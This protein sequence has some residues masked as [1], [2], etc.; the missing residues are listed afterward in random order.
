MPDPL[1]SLTEPEAKSLPSALTNTHSRHPSKA[2]HHTAR[3]QRH[4]DQTG[5][6]RHVGVPTEDPERSTFNHRL[7]AWYLHDDLGI[8]AWL[9]AWNGTQPRT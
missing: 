6:S 9:E 3:G 4:P 2:P 7:A 5:C 1:G 8:C